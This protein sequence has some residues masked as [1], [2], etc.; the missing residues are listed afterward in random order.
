MGRLLRVYQ[1]RLCP[2]STSTSQFNPYHFN[3]QTS[4]APFRRISSQ[5][6]HHTPAMD[7]QTQNNLASHF[8]SLHVPSKPL[9]LC[10]VHDAATALELSKNP[11]CQA[12]ATASYAVAE[13]HGVR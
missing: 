9:L 11:K 3:L 10:N 4:R 13:T 1:Q 6:R 2:L 8:K 7:A 12:I 5:N